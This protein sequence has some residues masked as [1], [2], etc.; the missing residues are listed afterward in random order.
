MGF[1]FGLLGRDLAVDLGTANTLVYARG[2]GVVLDEPS[3]VAVNMHTDRVMAVGTA[4]KEMIGRTPPHIVTMRPLK[5]GVIADLDAAE[6]MLRHFIQ[7]AHPNRF[8]ARPRVV[9]AVPSGTTG[10]EQRAVREAAYEAGARRVHIIEEPMA[11][12]IGAGL[13]VGDTS[14]NMVVDIGGGTTEVAIVSLGGVV[15]AKSVRVGGDELDEAVVAYV[16]KEH[17]LLLG[18]RTAEHIKITLGAARPG[19]DERASTPIRGRDLVT[20][21]PKTAT[22]TRGEV[23]EAIEDQVQTIVDAVQTTLDQCPAELA[24]DLLDNGIVLTGGG[25]LLDGLAERLGRAIGMPIHLVDEPLRSVVLGA[26]RCVERIDEMRDVFL[27]D[28][29][30]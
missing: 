27:P 30:R 25:A 2:R 24:G 20:G 29:R 3:V 8:L 26:G 23:R 21:L 28:N 12:A 1:P 14:G 19:G 16:K 15:V 9:V 22:I 4:A 17:G 13:N 18:E 5:D 7:R 10:V 6:R 11:A